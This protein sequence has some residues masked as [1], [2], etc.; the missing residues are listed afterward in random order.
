MLPIICIAYLVG[1]FAYISLFSLL[2]NRD[3]YIF[4]D[5]ELYLGFAPELV[6]VDLRWTELHWHSFFP[7]VLLF[8]P[9]SIILSWR[10]ILIYHLGDEQ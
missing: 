9:A 5:D 8:S 7:R 1:L 4:V 2:K 3:L 6:H 10:S